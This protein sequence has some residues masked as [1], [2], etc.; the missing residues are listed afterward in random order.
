MRT[1]AKL[2]APLLL[3]TLPLRADAWGF[4]GHNFIT[5]NSVQHLPDPLKFYFQQNLTTVNQYASNE[6][7]GRHYIDIDYYPEWAA[8]TFP[9]DENVLI[10][11]YGLST[12]QSNGES[13]W[14]IGNYRAT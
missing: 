13:P 11:K 1:R 6:P 10:A 3:L 5:A 7:P 4:Q 8:G 14:T 2:A 9:H 12:V